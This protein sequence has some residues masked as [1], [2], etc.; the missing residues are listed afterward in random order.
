MHVDQSERGLLHKWRI[1]SVSLIAGFVLSPWMS[2]F[3]IER[4]NSLFFTWT[5]VASLFLHLK[6]R[7]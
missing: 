1:R 6:N 2:L 7:E 3:N 4:I 5:H